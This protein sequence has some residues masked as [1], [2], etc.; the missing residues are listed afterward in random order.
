[1]RTGASVAAA[2][3]GSGPGSPTARP[4]AYR[5]PS[6]DSV[7]GHHGTLRPRI[8]TS[9]EIGG[10]A[11]QARGIDRSWV[12]LLRPGRAWI[13]V[14]MPPLRGYHITSQRSHSLGRAVG[15]RARPEGRHE[16][17]ERDPQL[18][19]RMSVDR[20]HLIGPEV[21]GPP[22]TAPGDDGAEIK[23]RERATWSA[24][25]VGWKTHDD[26]LVAFSN[27]VSEE[28]I[29]RAGI[30]PGMRV[31]D[32][33]SGTGEPSLSIAERVA[34]RG[35]VLGID[36]AEPMLA[37]AREKAVRRGLTNVEYREGDAESLG[38][39]EVAFDAATMRW[40]IMFLPD[41]VGALRNLH[42]T[43]KPGAKV[44]LA[45]WG[46][47]AQ[48][49]FLRL[50]MEVLRRHTEVPTPPPGGP[51]LFA[52]G[53]AARLPSTLNE[54]GFREVGSAEL[55][56]RMTNFRDGAEYWRFQRE[57]VGPIA[58]LYDP[59]PPETRAK[60]D[61]EVVAEAE[62]FRRY[63]TLDLPG[64]TWVGWGTR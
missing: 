49:P 46:P 47:P 16:V 59:L 19:E 33:A 58:R 48:N 43:L 17:A 35:S 34:P 31:L 9:G 14:P 23:E 15:S 28:L 26:A 20:P 5:D 32:L 2:N 7:G 25:S 44:A 56:L 3:H 52:F 64:M 55:A 13:D 40:G 36:L 50:P 53:D 42:R 21:L 4:G 10:V 54:A 57:I 51:G 39:P 18:G 6:P 1:M 8:E 41:P 27:P 22:M 29:R 24:A 38:L 62:K 45:A 12:C 63:D 30:V 61:A 37:V 11:R 60:V